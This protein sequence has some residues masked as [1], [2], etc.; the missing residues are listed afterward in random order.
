MTTRFSALKHAEW[1]HKAELQ[2]VE[3]EKN[4]KLTKFRNKIYHLSALAYPI[5]GDA[6]FR[7]ELCRG[8]FVDALEDKDFCLKVQQF[9][10]KSLDEA[11]AFARD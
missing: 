5:A 2:F 6:D 10:P 1:L 11:V 4:E 7:D 8:Q 9:R 3:R